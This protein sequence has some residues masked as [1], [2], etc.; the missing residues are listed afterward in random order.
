M[1]LNYKNQEY[2]ISFHTELVDYNAETN[3]EIFVYY[4]YVKGFSIC[5]EPDTEQ[6]HFLFADTKK[7]LINLLFAMAKDN[8]LHFIKN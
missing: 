6:K 3:K 5:Y 7:E 2:K 4:P 8:E 1:K